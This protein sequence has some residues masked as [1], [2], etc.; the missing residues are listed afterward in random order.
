MSACAKITGLSSYHKHQ[1]VH[2]AGNIYHLALYRKPLLTPALSHRQTPAIPKHVNFPSVLRNHLSPTM[3]AR[4]A[5]SLDCGS[6]QGG[7]SSLLRSLPI[8]STWEKGC[9]RTQSWVLTSDCAR[10]C[11]DWR[12]TTQPST[13]G[14]PLLLWAAGIVLI[15]YFN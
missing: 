10:W 3:E 4:C 14:K 11:G 12:G 15:Y 9:A 8:S 5:I 6:N 13:A 7:S 1:F 2:K